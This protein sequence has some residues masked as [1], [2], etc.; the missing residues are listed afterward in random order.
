MLYI[1]LFM[2]YSSLLMI[3][4]LLT[5]DYLSTYS[6]RDPNLLGFSFLILEFQ[7]TFGYLTRCL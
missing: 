1:S 5:D 7:P 4:D 3:T 6:L 2:L